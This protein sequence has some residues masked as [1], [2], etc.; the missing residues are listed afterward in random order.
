MTTDLHL[1]DPSP[2]EENQITYLS[3]SACLATMSM[4]LR[5][6][7]FP[8]LLPKITS[9]LAPAS[10]TQSRLTPPRIL[11][12]AFCQSQGLRLTITLPLAVYSSLSCLWA[13]LWDPFLRAV[14]KKKTSH[15]KK[16]QRFLAGKALKDVIN[17]NTCSACGNVKR[18][19]LLCP[20]CIE[21][22]SSAVSSPV[23]HLMRFRYSEYVEA[24]RTGYLSPANLDGL[25]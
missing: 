4:T 3:V 17:L 19:H 5:R 6:A 24:E 12:Q 1:H 15:R 25:Q 18:A 11:T 20:Y 14:P 7:N 16:R 2:Q 22:D 13:L 8:G 23:I 9:F 10:P 21:G